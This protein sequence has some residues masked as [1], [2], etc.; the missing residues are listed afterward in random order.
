MAFQEHYKI[1][2]GS[3]T[4]DEPGEYEEWYI[5]DYDDY[6]QFM[7]DMFSTDEARQKCKLT[8]EEFERAKNLRQDVV[9]FSDYYPEDCDSLDIIPKRLTKDIMY[10]LVKETVDKNSKKG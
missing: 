1:I 5:G 9:E 3:I 4:L 7:N 8:R 6:D 2:N 10:T